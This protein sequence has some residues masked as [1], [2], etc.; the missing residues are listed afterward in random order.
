M[1]LTILLV[2]SLREMTVLRE[3]AAEDGTLNIV[4][5]VELIRTIPRHPSEN[6][7]SELL[8][9]ETEGFTDEQLVQGKRFYVEFVVV[10]GESVEPYSY[11]INT[12]D[13]LTK[14]MKE[15]DLTLSNAM[16]LLCKRPD[17]SEPRHGRL[18]GIKLY[19][20]IETV[21]EDNPERSV[22]MTV[23]L[24]KWLVHWM[25]EQNLNNSKLV[26]N[27]L[28]SHYDL[29]LLNGSVEVKKDS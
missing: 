24:P 23:F 26:E 10:R 27:A 17:K 12:V 2:F 29:Q 13:V 6:E 19:E 20:P 14:L 18:V 1:E 3:S 21:E 25:S 11:E 5:S 8:L 7:L 16:M 22:P 9:K 15:N 28:I 4:E